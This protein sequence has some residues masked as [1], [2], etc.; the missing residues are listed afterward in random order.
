MKIYEGREGAG[1]VKEIM[2]NRADGDMRQISEAVASILAD[3]KNNGDRALAVYAKQYE[4]TDYEINPLRVREAEIDEAYRQCPAA[5]LS[6]L[7]NMIENV[8]NF[9]SKQLD[10]GYELK[11]E[12]GYT[13][14]IIRPIGTA[15][16]YAPGGTAAY[17]SSVVMNIVPA[18][19]AGVGRICMATPAKAGKL[20]PLTLV[21]ARESGVDEVYR[22]GGAQA[23][24]AFA[25]GT[26]TV[27]RVDKITGP[28]NAYVAEAK[29]QLFGK[30]G[31]DS[32]AGPS[33]ILVVADSEAN[34]SYAAA[35]LLSQAEHDERAAAIMATNSM[36]LARNVAEQVATQMER[37][38]R[39]EI[40][41]KSIEDYGSIVVLGSIE[42]CIEFANDI[43]PEHLELL[44]HDPESMLPMVK[45]AGGIF[46]GEYSPEPLGD[47]M[48][49]TNHVLPT[50]GNAKFASPLGVYDFVKRS[51]VV[52]FSREQ[53]E[54]CADDIRMLASAEGLDAHAEAIAIR[55]FNEE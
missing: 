24:A 45:N 28:G 42:E 2:R 41:R 29:R 27:P 17:P 26:E 12:A 22:M 10:N 6:A 46:L 3:I 23:I 32:V 51:G 35:D 18:K 1:R 11:S 48:A 8:K 14:Q 31:I 21:A 33:E 34:A 49:G 55:F 16:I 15:G 4:G 50:D 25:Y 38:P 53:L 19:L 39:C 52:G 36:E 20:P 7:R 44:L 54:R 13:A 40:A 47:Y 37:L 9:H 5:L 30:V 43:A